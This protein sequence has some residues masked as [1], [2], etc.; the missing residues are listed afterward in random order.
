M[1]PSHRSDNVKQLARFLNIELHR[2]PAGAVDTLQPLDRIVFEAL[3]SRARR[4][5]RCPVETDRG[6]RGTKTEAVEDVMQ[7]WEELTEDVVQEG[8]DFDKHWEVI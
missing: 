6:V 7:A 2:I 5:F 8:W 1:H 4:L 3:K